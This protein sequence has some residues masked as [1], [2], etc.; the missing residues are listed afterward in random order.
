MDRHSALPDGPGLSRLE[1]TLRWR[2]RP[3]E[4]L[5]ACHIRCGEIFTLRPLGERPFVLASGPE[6]I[7]QIFALSYEEVRQEK[8]ALLA[9]LL[10]PSSLFVVEGQEHA[11]IRRLAAPA[12]HRDRVVQQART[13]QEIT[14]AA[15]GSWPLG[16]PF[17]L[18]TAMQELTLQT[19]LR[20]LLGDHC[21]E[22]RSQLARI[23]SVASAELNSPLILVP[24]EW[25]QRI[26]RGP[27]LRLVRGTRQ[28]GA[29]LLQEIAERRS[30][31]AGGCPVANDVLSGLL[32]ARDSGGRPLS[33]E[34]ARDTIIALLTAGRDTTADALSWALSCLLESPG[35]CARLREEL[36]GATENGALVPER[37]S[38]LPLL[39]AAVRESLRLRPVFSGVH[40]DLLAPT[41]LAGHELAAG[42][43]VVASIYLAQRRRESFP[44]PERFLPDRFL[45]RRPT[46]F[47]WLPFGGGLRRCLGIE[48]GLLQMK[49]VLATILHHAD[50]RPAAGP[51][52]RPVP[53]WLGIAPSRGLPAILA[54]RTT[55]R[56]GAQRA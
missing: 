24:A 55:R 56:P 29:L 44:D 10:G 22:R 51:P 53:H 36:R 14:E 23:I 54:S 35:T 3:T 30:E 33:D 34:E 19:M 28:A 13:I 6:A 49:V 8:S 46:P 11:R 21:G 38:A 52:T 40:R 32:A 15:I 4:F 9:D 41:R 47:E 42:T 12:L 1:Q 5:D 25:Q 2:L 50:L 26:G 45:S 20:S 17:R 16:A 31:Q 48:S 18:Q 43:R 39:D 27:W 7:R 37:L